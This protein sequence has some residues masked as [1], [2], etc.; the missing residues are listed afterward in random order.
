[1]AESG[2]FED[3]L[4]LERPWYVDRIRF[5]N[6]TR[7]LLI[8]LDFEAGATFTCGSCGAGGCKAYDTAPKQW[9]H[10]DFLGHPAF[11]CG[12]SPRVECPACGIRQAELPWARR[13]Q[14]LTVPFEELVVTLAR[15]MPMVAVSRLL[16]EHDTRLRRVVINYED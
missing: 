9:R 3:A 1:M 12:P 2:I 6:T 5:E 10:L 7:K 15:E 8:D 11:L 4:G 16:G 14:R 13:W